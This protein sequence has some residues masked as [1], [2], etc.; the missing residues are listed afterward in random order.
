LLC[1][2][3]Q[4]IPRTIK[5]TFPA[6]KLWSFSSAPLASHSPETILILR[7]LSTFEALYLSRSTNRLNEII[8]QS[9]SGGARTPPGLNEGLN[10][11]RAIVNEMDSARFDPLLVKSV[12]KNVNGCL[13]GM[14]G[15]AD[16]LVSD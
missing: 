6:I 15:R 4:Y 7:A 12:A 8:A 9:F 10:N 2:L 13:E 14:I 3:I 5:G 11:A 16:G 1:I